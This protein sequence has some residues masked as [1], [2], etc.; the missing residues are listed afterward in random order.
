[1][2]TAKDKFG[3]IVR[4]NMSNKELEKFISKNKGYTFEDESVNS[5]FNIQITLV[6]LSLI[7]LI[8]IWL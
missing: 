6:V 3:K 8:I 2:W 5:E 1:M 4:S 7:A